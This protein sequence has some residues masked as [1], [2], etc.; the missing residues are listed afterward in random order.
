MPRLIAGLA[1]LFWLFSLQSP[2]LVN[3]GLTGNTNA[4]Q[5]SYR[6]AEPDR[7]IEQGSYPA[8]REWMK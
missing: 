1:A 6:N 8:V 4:Q 3:R 5:Q 2:N 7:N